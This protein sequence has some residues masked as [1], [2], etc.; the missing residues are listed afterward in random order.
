MSICTTP[1]DRVHS[2]VP[3]STGDPSWASAASFV[4]DSLPQQLSPNRA[5]P[6]V[7]DTHVTLPMRSPPPSQSQYASDLLSA[8]SVNRNRKPRWDHARPATG[9]PLLPRPFR[10]SK[11]YSRIWGQRQAVSK[12]SWHNSKRNFELIQLKS[13]SSGN[14][15]PEGFKVLSLCLMVAPAGAAITHLPSSPASDFLLFFTTIQLPTRS[16]RSVRLVK[17]TKL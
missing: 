3:S 15:A 10:R 2:G 14:K 7:V 17:G 5:P 13:N 12:P 8:V 11:A 1:G 9:H 16:T 4:V 6:S